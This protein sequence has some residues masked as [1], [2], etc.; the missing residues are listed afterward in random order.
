MK[1]NPSMMKKN[2]STKSPTK[3][4]RKNIMKNK[5]KSIMKNKTIKKIFR[6]Q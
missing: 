1:T 3:K 5:R 4:I 6:G 2:P